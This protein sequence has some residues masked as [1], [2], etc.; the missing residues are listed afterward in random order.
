MK[1]ELGNSEERGRELSGG[2]HLESRV[3]T[4]EHVLPVWLW[5]T[6]RGGLGGVSSG[7][8]LDKRPWPDLR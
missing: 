3:T 4:H 6:S 5:G 7:D 2:G 1:R 8:F